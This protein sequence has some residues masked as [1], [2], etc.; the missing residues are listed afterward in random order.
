MNEEFEVRFK[1]IS[2]T[3]DQLRSGD[4]DGKRTRQL[5]D[6]LFRDV[7]SLKAA[8]NA[9]GLDDLASRTHEFENLL[10]D[11]R[12][13]KA[14][15]NPETLSSFIDNKPL[16]YELNSPVP[17]AQIENLIPAEIRGALKDEERHR[18]AEC[19][20]EGANL[21]LVETSFDVASFDRQFQQLKEELT[22]TGEVIATAPKTEDGKINFRILFAT[23]SDL[24]RILDQAVR[25]GRA[26]AE[27]TGK[28]VDFSI[29]VDASLEK[30]VCDALAD[31]LMHLVRNAVDHGI[32]TKGHVG[33]EATRTRIVV[34]DD[35]RGID[36]SIIDRI[37]EPGFST[38]T[39]VTTISGRG[40]G[41]DVVKT[42]IEKLRGAISVSSEP[43]K[44]STFEILLPR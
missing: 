32:V 2:A 29:R 15:L 20:A 41:L 36:P 37:F 14:T 38:A 21:Y 31:S 8:A 30:S 13:G 19:M 5:L 3:I 44:G 39:E 43:G 1:Q 23:K 33:I 9:N 18:L 10:H 22:K 7:H 6:T 34:K 12:T 17:L 4:G 28:E 40:V 42:A 35:G 25:A 11:I 27:S 16:Q 26:V 24:Y